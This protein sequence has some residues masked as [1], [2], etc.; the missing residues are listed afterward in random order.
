M[1]ALLFLLLAFPAVAGSIKTI[2]IVFEEP[3]ACGQ[4]I[5]KM[6]EHPVSIRCPKNFKPALA[7]TALP[8][9]TAPLGQVLGLIRQ[10]EGVRRAEISEIRVLPSLPKTY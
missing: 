3:H 8:I 7:Y 10:V 2:T 6:R 9:G 4:V 1:K 5:H